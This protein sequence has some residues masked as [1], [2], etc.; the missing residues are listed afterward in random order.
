MK[1]L[2]IPDEAVDEL[3]DNSCPEDFGLENINKCGAFGKKILCIDC[4]NQH[5]KEDGEVE[6]G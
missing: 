4:W 3:I 5:L 1:T 2:L 6:Q